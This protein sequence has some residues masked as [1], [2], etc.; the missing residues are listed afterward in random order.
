[1]ALTLERTLTRKSNGEHRSSDSGPGPE[2]FLHRDW[3]EPPAAHPLVFGFSVRE[4]D[5][6]PFLLLRFRVYPSLIV[7]QSGGGDGFL[8]RTSKIPFLYV[9]RRWSPFASASSSVTLSETLLIFLYY[10]IVL[11]IILLYIFLYWYCLTISS[12]IR[13]LPTLW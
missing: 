1:M 10:I 8:F 3:S 4:E 12:E 13:L 6:A 11:C 9:A 7:A 5:Y 2:L